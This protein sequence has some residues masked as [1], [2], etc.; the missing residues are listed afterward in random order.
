MKKER[1]I[2]RS[3]PSF[4]KVLSTPYFLV[5]ILLIII[6]IFIMVL[7]SFQSDNISGVFKISFT[8]NHYIS[9]FKE[10]NFIKVMSKSI[11]LALISTFITLIIGYPI[12]YLISTKK[13]RTQAILMTLV[14]SPLWINMLL[15]TL[16]LKQVIDL[17]FKGLI[18]T[19]LAVIIGMVYMFLPFMIIPIYTVLQKIDPALIEAAEDLGASK[20]Q[21]IGKVIIPLSFSGIISGIMMV[22]LPAATTL[23]VPKYLGNGMYLIGNLI[24]DI[25]LKQGRFGYGSAI[26][27]ILSLIMMGLV[28]LLRKSNNYRGGAKNDQKV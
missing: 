1:N 4:V 13:P 11:Y 12:A 26:A 20:S 16:A 18:G 6:P 3:K 22:L 24:E 2:K 27:I 10:K 8:L 15:R 21:I 14:T 17:F 7:Y 25:I 9:F 5:L 28:F 19:N 23:V